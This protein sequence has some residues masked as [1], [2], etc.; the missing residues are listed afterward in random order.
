MS[1]GRASLGYTVNIGDY[2]SVRID[3][4]VEIDTEGDVDEQLKVALKAIRKA[5]L[6][7]ES[8]I[9]E[10]LTELE[11]S[12]INTKN[13]ESLVKRLDKIEKDNID[14]R[15]QLGKSLAKEGWYDMAFVV[16][17]RDLLKLL[18]NIAQASRGIQYKAVMGRSKGTSL[19]IWFDS[20]EGHL[21][22][23]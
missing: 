13:F 9:G 6:A 8:Q 20:L 19:T 23:F 16:D 1:K 5:W 3:A 10:A 2:Q 18:G 14:I 7:E 12:S 4:D 15:D 11:M 22:Q 21:W 17:R